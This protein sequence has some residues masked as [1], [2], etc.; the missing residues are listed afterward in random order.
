MNTQNVKTAAPESSERWDVKA[1]LFKTQSIGRYSV[2][3]SAPCIGGGVNL[4]CSHITNASSSL[5]AVARFQRETRAADCSVYAVVE[6]EPVQP[7]CMSTA[8]YRLVQKGFIWFCLDTGMIV[9]VAENGNM[10]RGDD[11]RTLPAY[12]TLTRI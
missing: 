11:G 4:N 12:G 5:D 10:R 3:F 8:G 1:C 2:K 7:V 9:E 6:I